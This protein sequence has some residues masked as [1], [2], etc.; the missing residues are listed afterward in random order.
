MS[1]FAKDRPLSA[2][3]TNPA[4]TRFKIRITTAN[5]DVLYWHKRGRLHT[6]EED[7]ADIFCRQF[8][9]ELFE[10]LPD[11]SLTPPQPGVTQRIASLKKEPATPSE[12]EAAGEA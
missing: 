10:V 9:P 5:G 6:V 3:A 7:V 11:G 12:N 4:A 2:A 8:K 1:I